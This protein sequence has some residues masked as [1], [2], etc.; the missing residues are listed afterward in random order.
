MATQR[1]FND[2]DVPPAS[3]GGSVSQGIVELLSA[4]ETG[5]EFWSRHPFEV[6]TELQLRLHLG[7]LPGALATLAKTDG[8]QTKLAFVVQ[9]TPARRA[10]GAVGFHVSVL[11][12]PEPSAPKARFASSEAPTFETDKANRKIGL[13]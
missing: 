13:N 5:L 10:N 7:S 12:L 2:D 3:V 4:T 11:Y 6:A 9:C 1:H 8:W